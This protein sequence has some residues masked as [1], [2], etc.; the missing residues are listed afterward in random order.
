MD[1]SK[2]NSTAT[3]VSGG[4]PPASSHLST[5]PPNANTASGETA[6]SNALNDNSFGS[7]LKKQRASVSE[8]NDTSAQI[9]T[10]EGVTGTIGEVLGNPPGS[11]KTAISGLFGENIKPQGPAAPQLDVDEEL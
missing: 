1:S 6:Q 2:T 3:P 11:S 7:P 10:E 5:T 8:T 9:K 4:T